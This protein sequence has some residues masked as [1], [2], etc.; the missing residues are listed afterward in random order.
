MVWSYVA[1]KFKTSQASWAWSV[2]VPKAEKSTSTHGMCPASCTRNE[3]PLQDRGHIHTNQQ[4][5]TWVTKSNYFTSGFEFNATSFINVDKE[6]FDLFDIKP[7]LEISKSK[8]SIKLSTSTD[9]LDR[10]YQEAQLYA[11]LV[12]EPFTVLFWGVCVLWDNVSTVSVG[13]W[14]RGGVTP[15]FIMNIIFV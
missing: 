12:E 3:I 2:C 10:A 13:D 1:V 8:W 5:E 6:D 15:Q 11:D 9:E 7:T 4:I 14:W